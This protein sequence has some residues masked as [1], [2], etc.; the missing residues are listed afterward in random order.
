MDRLETTLRRIDGRGYKAYKDIEGQYDF[1]D[2]ILRVDHVQGDPFAEPSRVSVVVALP[3]TWIAV[4]MHDTA[5]RVIALR[6]FVARRFA[7]AL[8]SV[9]RKSRGSGKS[10]IISIDR[11]GQEVLERSACMLGNGFVEVRFKVGLPA[12]G[13]RVLGRE[14]FGLLFDDVPRLV[15][16]TF[17][18]DHS[19]DAWAHVKCVEDADVARRQLADRGLVAFVAKG[20]ILPRQSGI[21]DGPMQEGAVEFGPVPESFET[22]LTLPHAG[23][24]TGLGIP[25]GVTLI[26]GGGYHGKSTV[27]KAISAGVY[28]HIPGDGRE[29]VVAD[30]NASSI[31]AEDG[32]R[33]EKVDISPFIAALPFGKSTT[34]F[35]TADASGSTSQAA[36][37]VEALEAGATTLIIDEDTSA[38]NFMIRDHRMQKLVAREQEPIIP[39]IDR[40]KELHSAR[41]VSTILVLGGSGD[42]FDVADNV[43]QMH[44]YRPVDVTAQA[45]KI[46]A[47]HPARRANESATPLTDA[48]HRIPLPRSF[49]PSKGRRAEKVRSMETRS[50]LFGTEE[51][52][53]NLVEQLLDPSQTRFIADVMLHIH[54]NYVDG[55]TALP[56]LVDQA[57]QD[58]RTGSLDTLTHGRFGNRA[59]ARPLEIAAAINR[60]RTLCVNVGHV[61]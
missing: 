48:A 57:L 49:D 21:D 42:Y 30:E 38:T 43:I 23:T 22:N 7:R 4:E 51:I 31:R 12:A 6:D 26:V 13:R 45:R 55:E 28:N 16:E 10:G 9:G 5:V 39:F 56:Q 50:I 8:V 3:R 17:E 27:L 47:E 58:V 20:A 44:E 18:P 11:P 33:V 15:K 36:N 46:C 53:I 61:S 54:R 32:R 41:G 52:D 14:A 24:V 59:V 2:F 34:A 25:K 35:C 60:L 1:G 37:I 19:E 29:L 40:V